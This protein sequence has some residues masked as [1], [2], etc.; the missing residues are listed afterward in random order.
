MIYFLILLYLNKAVVSL[1]PLNDHKVQPMINDNC[2]LPEP[3]PSQIAN[4][5]TPGNRCSQSSPS[6]SLFPVSRHLRSF[7]PVLVDVEEVSSIGAFIDFIE[8]EGEG[9]GSFTDPAGLPK[10]SSTVLALYQNFCK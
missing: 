9:E 5:I 7:I 2:E 6:S 3:L 10:E 4:D 1:S 8:G